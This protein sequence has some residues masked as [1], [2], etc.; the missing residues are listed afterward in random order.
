ARGGSLPDGTPLAIDVVHSARVR[1]GVNGGWFL[2]DRHQI[3]QNR[4]AEFLG[5]VSRLYHLYFRRGSRSA[6]ASIFSNAYNADFRLLLRVHWREA[7]E[8]RVILVF[9][10]ANFLFGDDLRS[11]R[12]ATGVDLAR[13]ADSAR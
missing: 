8:P 12:L 6:P 1:G 2:V 11:A 5:E 9:L 10:A 3:R 4:P 13:K 7:D